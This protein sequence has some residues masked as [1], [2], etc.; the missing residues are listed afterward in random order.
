MEEKNCFNNHT[1]AL[2]HR[3]FKKTGVYAKALTEEFIK[4]DEELII[5]IDEKQKTLESK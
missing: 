4:I 1:K 3:Y 5:E 2:K